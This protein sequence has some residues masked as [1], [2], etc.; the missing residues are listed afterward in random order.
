[1]L[2]WR[3]AGAEAAPVAF[4][5]ADPPRPDAA[6]AVSAL[7]RIGLGVEILSGDSPG[8]VSAVAAAVGVEEW[9]AGAS[10]ADK[11]ARIEALRAEGRRPLMVGDGINDAAAMGLAHVSASPGGGADLAQDAADFVLRG[12]GGAGGLLPV[13]EAVAVARRARRIARQSLGFSLSY[14]LVAVP[15]AVAGLVTPLGAAVVMATSS[16]AVIGN[17]LRAG[18]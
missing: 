15:A 6:E 4:R 10:P 9:R 16:L 3:P 18:H 2:W 7:R 12:G 8:A 14:N 1:V 11:A 5:F 17:A 13:A